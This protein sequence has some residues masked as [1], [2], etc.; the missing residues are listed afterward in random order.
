[1][2]ASVRT[3]EAVGLSD[4]LQEEV[5]AMIFVK[6]FFAGVA[7]LIMAALPIYGLAVV[8][9]RILELVPHGEGGMFVYEVGPF[10]IWPLVVAA[11]LI[12]CSGFYWNFRRA[13]RD[14]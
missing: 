14:R 1:M 5:E 9:P 11:L 3:C 7:A 10:P 12:F 4:N 2:T 8:V 13:Q 6:S